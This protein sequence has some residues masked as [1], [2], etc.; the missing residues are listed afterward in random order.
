M[1]FCWGGGGGEEETPEH[2]Q[3]GLFFSL[4]DASFRTSLFMLYI[5]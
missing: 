4:D 5:I 2:V 1:V 3:H